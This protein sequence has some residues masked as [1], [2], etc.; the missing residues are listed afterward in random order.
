MEK[1]KNEIFVSCSPAREMT[2]GE[3]FAVLDG[4]DSGSIVSIWFLFVLM[5]YC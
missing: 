2:D 4:C 3:P 1:K 5:L